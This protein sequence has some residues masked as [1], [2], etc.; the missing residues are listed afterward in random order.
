MLY[1]NSI[2]KC[3]A[4]QNVCIGVICLTLKFGQTL[5]EKKKKEKLFTQNLLRKYYSVC[6]LK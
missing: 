4:I 3:K 2:A 1:I 5:K 6:A